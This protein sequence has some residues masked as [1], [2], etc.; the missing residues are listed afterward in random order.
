MGSREYYIKP[1]KERIFSFSYNS[2]PFFPRVVNFA[3]FF[4]FSQSR[5]WANG[6]PK[7]L[8][9]SNCKTDLIDRF[10][11][12]LPKHF[13]V[14]VFYPYAPA[15]LPASGFGLYLNGY[16]NT[17]PNRADGKTKVIKL[18]KNTQKTRT[19]YRYTYFGWITTLV[20]FPSEKLVPVGPRR[21]GIR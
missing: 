6:C 4:R 18:K 10:F 19:C 16:L 9:R 17:E 13:V 15:S 21:V 2:H 7:N 20:T 5:R 1:K 11:Y 3:V 12:P 14:S 8:G